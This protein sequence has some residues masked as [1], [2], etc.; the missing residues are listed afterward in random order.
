MNESIKKNDSY[1]SEKINRKQ[2]KKF[3]LKKLTI[4]FNL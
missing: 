1:N 4:L 3:R 2:R